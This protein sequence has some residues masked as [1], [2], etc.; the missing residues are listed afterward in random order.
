MD[1]YELLYNASVA[2]LVLAVVIKLLKTLFGPPA[3]GAESLDDYKR[4]HPECVKNGRVRCYRCGSASIYLYRWGYGPGWITNLHL[5]RQC[6]TNLYR[7]T[8]K[9]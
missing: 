3:G 4:R 8:I 1:K 7:S 9:T 5:C 6:G 2:L